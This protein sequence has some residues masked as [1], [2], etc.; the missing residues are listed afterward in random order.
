M[1]TCNKPT[2]YDVDVQF[3]TIL[4][5]ESY[6]ESCVTLSELFAKVLQ[7][8]FS[9]SFPAFSDEGVFGIA[10][11]SVGLTTQR[12]LLHEEF[13][14]LSKS[15]RKL[16]WTC[17]IVEEETEYKVVFHKRQP[18]PCIGCRKQ[19]DGEDEQAYGRFCCLACRLDTAQANSSEF[20][21]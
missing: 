8:P 5:P 6:A 9:L 2:K 14:G 3:G 20:V 13:M 10:S 16:N 12:P 7:A 11:A 19:V 1:T 18:M 15:L 4:L 21:L 17:A